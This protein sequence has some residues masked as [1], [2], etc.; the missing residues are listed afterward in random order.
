MTTTT[1]RLPDDGNDMPDW[2]EI[3]VEVPE[4]PVDSF[5][6]RAGDMRTDDGIDD[7]QLGRALAHAGL[8]VDYR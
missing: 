6:Q 1:R 7:R 8:H 3:A 5:V 4:D 2:T